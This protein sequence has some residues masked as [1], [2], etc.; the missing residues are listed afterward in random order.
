RRVPALCRTGRIGGDAA[1]DAADRTSRQLAGRKPAQGR[2]GRETRDQGGRQAVV[3]RLR[4]KQSPGRD[5][6]R[7][8]NPQPS[9]P[10]KP[11]MTDWSLDHARRIWSIPHWSEGYY[12]VD[13]S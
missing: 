4:L 13:D 9:D 5:T 10:G 1:P 12:D 2:A 6:L 11:P 8:Y 3:P 7:G